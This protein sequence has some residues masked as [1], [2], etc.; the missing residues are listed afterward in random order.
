VCTGPYQFGYDPVV[1]VEDELDSIDLD[2]TEYADAK[3][4][5]DGEYAT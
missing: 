3:R 1:T 5:P 2:E 4:G